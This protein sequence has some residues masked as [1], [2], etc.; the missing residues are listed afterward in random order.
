MEGPEAPPY[1]PPLAVKVMRVSAPFFASRSVPMFETCSEG[2]QELQVPHSVTHVDGEVWDAIKSTYARGSDS[3]FTDAPT[4]LRDMVYTDQLVLPGSFGTVSV[5]ETFHAI[6][7][8]TNTSPDMV[9]SVRLMV[10]LRSDK[11]D[12]FASTMHMLADVSA[13]ELAAGA[14]LTAKVCHSIDTPVTH[15]LVCH[16]QHDRPPVH[17]FAKQYRFPIH[18]PPFVMQSDIH[19]LDDTHGAGPHACHRTLVR[20]LLQNTSSRPLRLEELALDTESWHASSVDA[21]GHIFMPQDIRAYVFVLE[22]H[23]PISPL[24][25]RDAL[26]NATDHTQLVSCAIPLGHVQVAWRIPKGEPGRLRIGPLHHHLRLPRPVHGLFADLHLEAHDAWHVD[27][28]CHAT[29]HLNVWAIETSLLGSET[30]LTLVMDDA[31]DH[32]LMHGPHQHT[33]PVVLEECMNF[34]IPCELTPL[35]RGLVPTGGM[36]LQ[37]EQATVRAWK[38]LAHIHTT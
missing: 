27:Q 8:V 4:T 14:Q 35:R 21:C 5:G 25:F 36:M 13:P 12:K 9:R 10:E 31:W 1:V 24:M 34:R 37:H 38:R 33:L 23:T 15:A 3:T 16:M 6:V 18:S 32:V 17:S 19:T 7:S 28:T 2:A 11:T 26:L 20:L 29:L 22:P 30:R